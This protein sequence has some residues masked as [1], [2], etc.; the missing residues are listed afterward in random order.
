MMGLTFLAVCGLT[1]LAASLC[2]I[3]MHSNNYTSRVEYIVLNTD[4]LDASVEPSEGTG[5]H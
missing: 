2:P 1:A 3:S 5:Q 4:R